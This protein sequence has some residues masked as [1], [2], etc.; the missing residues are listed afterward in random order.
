MTDLYAAMQQYLAVRRALGFKLRQHEGLL[1]DF[2][3]FMDD[4]GQTTITIDLAVAWA[5]ASTKADPY[6]WKRRLGVIR[7]FS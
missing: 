2:A 5:T 6:T 4:R 7:N 3:Q 1:R